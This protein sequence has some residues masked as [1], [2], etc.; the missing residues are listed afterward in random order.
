MT[1]DRWHGHVREVTKAQ[2]LWEPRAYSWQS[3][4]KQLVFK[5]DLGSQSEDIRNHEHLV[6]G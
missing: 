5:P 1:S 3:S 6:S 4:S 2:V